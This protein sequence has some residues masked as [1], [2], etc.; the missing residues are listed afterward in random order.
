MTKGNHTKWIAVSADGEILADKCRWA[1]NGDLVFEIKRAGTLH[2]V[3][4]LIEAYTYHHID[5]HQC[6]VNPGDT[7]SLSFRPEN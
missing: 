2:A 7:V 1:D 4:P 5:K 6:H 3:M